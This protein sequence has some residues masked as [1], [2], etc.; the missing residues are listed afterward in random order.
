MVANAIYI[1]NSLVNFLT[2]IYWLLFAFKQLFHLFKIPLKAFTCICCSICSNLRFYAT[3]SI[4]VPFLNVF[5]SFAFLIIIFV[6][7]ILPNHL[8]KH[9]YIWETSTRNAFLSVVYDIYIYILKCIPYISL[10]ALIHLL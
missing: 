4:V 10:S 7:L 6:C 3:T 8:S 1:L 2:V 5:L 9:T